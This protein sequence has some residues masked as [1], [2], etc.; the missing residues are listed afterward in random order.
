MMEIQV[1][2]DVPRDQEVDFDRLLGR[3]SEIIS[4]ELKVRKYKFLLDGEIPADEE[5]NTIYIERR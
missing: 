5:S 4:E 2:I 3:L 1:I